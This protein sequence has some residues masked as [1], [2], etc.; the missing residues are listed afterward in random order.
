MK[1]IVTIQ[2]CDVM[3]SEPTLSYLA[4]KLKK[5][6]SEWLSAVQVGTIK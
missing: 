3:P 1:L 4:S 5:N 2:V 6:S